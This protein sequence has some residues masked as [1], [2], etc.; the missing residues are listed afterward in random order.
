VR[1]S[2]IDGYRPPEAA[3]APIEPV[4]VRVEAFEPEQWTRLTIARIR[5]NL[6]QLERL[7]DRKANAR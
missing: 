5:Q 4:P 2:I 6:D 3:P 1:D 7:L